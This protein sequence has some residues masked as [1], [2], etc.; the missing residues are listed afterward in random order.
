MVQVILVLARS[1]EEELDTV[2]TDPVVAP[3]QGRA[4]DGSDF[5]L[6]VGAARGL[7]GRSRAR[8]R[9]TG[10]VENGDRVEVVAPSGDLALSEGEHRD[11][12]VGVVGA[13]CDNAAF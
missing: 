6:R 11:V 10:S 2:A 9:P 13:G 7:E 5:A 8:R 12:A 4:T 1:R 3:E